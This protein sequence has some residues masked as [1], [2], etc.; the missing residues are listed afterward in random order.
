ME[1]AV[2]LGISGLA[3]SVG[4]GLV[5]LASGWAKFRHRA[6]LG[7]VVANYRILPQ[8]LVAPAAAA[9]P[10]LEMSV[11]AALIAGMGVLPALAAI[12]LLLAFAAAMAV[13]IRRGRAHIDCGCGL[14]ALRQPLSRLLVARNLMLAALLALRIVPAPA[15]SDAEISAAAVGGL[16]LF[17]C[18][19]LFNAIGAL[20]QSSAAA[21]RR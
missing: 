5:F 4:I 1:S 19:L 15:L 16:A 8:R 17:L 6:V 13:N 20:S 7:G 11:G 12:G 21:F 14:S 9:L 2:G 10:Y 18:Y 3:A